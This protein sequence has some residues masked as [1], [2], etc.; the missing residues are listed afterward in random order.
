MYDGIFASNVTN[1]QFSAACVAKIAQNDFDD[2]IFFHGIDNCFT[3]F[4]DINSINSLSFFDIVLHSYGVL[5]Q[6]MNHSIDHIIPM[7]P[8]I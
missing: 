3:L 6:Y 5:L 8:D 2:N 1:N 4:P 7:L